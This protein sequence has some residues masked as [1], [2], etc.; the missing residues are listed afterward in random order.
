MGKKVKIISSIIVLLIL[1]GYGAVL[2]F[3]KWFKD[4][5]KKHATF[6]AKHRERYPEG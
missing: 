4:L 2:F 6:S 3:G 1:G 5:L